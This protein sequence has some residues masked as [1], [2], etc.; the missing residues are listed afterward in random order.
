MDVGIDDNDVEIAFVSESISSDTT[1]P[2]RNVSCATPQPPSITDRQP[3][4]SA[5]DPYSPGARPPSRSSSSAYVGSSLLD[6]DTSLEE[7]FVP[8]EDTRNLQQQRLLEDFLEMEEDESSHINTSPQ[9][10]STFNDKKSPHL[11]LQQGP[12]FTNSGL[13]L[14][15]RRT[16]N[17]PS[18]S[19]P[20][21]K[22]NEHVMSSLPRNLHR[23]GFE[24]EAP[25]Y[26]SRSNNNVWNVWR[27]R[28]S[29]VWI[30]LALS[31]VIFMAG[32][33]ILWHHVSEVDQQDA[34]SNH[35]NLGI[36][37]EQ[38]EEENVNR[39]V[40]LPMDVEDMEHQQLQHVMYLPREHEQHQDQHETPHRRLSEWQEAFE[41]W[42]QHHGKRYSTEEERQYRLQ[43]WMENHRRTARKN[44]KH[45]PCPL[46]QRPV[47]GN[48]NH[49]QDLTHAE[50]RSQYLNAQRKPRK[51]ESVHNAGTL[52]PDVPTKRHADVHHRIVQQQEGKRS[53]R[54]RTQK[55]YSC[56]WYDVS[57]NLRYFIE[58]YFY[59]YFGIGRTMEPAYDKDSYPNSIDWRELGAVTEVRAQD[60][61]GACW[62][63]TA[64]ETVES[65][66]FLATGELITLSETEVIL[67]NED[68]K[69]CAGGW[70][71]N[72][73]DYIMENK[74]I[75]LQDDLGYD[76]Q[77][78]S[79]ISNVLAGE[80]DELR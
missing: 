4:W 71:E 28:V 70:P 34:S 79:K 26:R 19:R 23:E 68:C 76:G 78:L 72:A 30:W 13:L 15:H 7:A 54:P 61:C 5:Y 36:V 39:I 53:D 6:E 74:G 44:E 69:M 8:S 27:R 41:S 47:F 48:S 64:V 3:N 65:A 2:R 17:T 46:T 1:E 52:G 57:C 62:A 38:M 80:S 60:N 31:A 20:P 22:P 67:C 50:F 66:L 49:F 43:V 35:Q 40:L 12:I 59:G 24:V 32:T 58:K 16:T 9:T 33:A 73:F 37:P 14:T 21:L 77:Y 18:S 56:K 75:P 51:L 42:A 45:G 55:A 29:L 63:I 10:P 11:G 25:G